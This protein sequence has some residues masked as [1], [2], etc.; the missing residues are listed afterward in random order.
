MPWAM[1]MIEA[2][3]ICYDIEI[4]GDVRKFYFR[5]KYEKHMYEDVR[6]FLWKLFNQ[7]SNQICSDA[8]TTIEKDM[9]EQPINDE[10][11]QK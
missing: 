6:S 10:R 1:V 9:D 4:Q 11:K 8:I 3:E 7:G 5:P 2:H